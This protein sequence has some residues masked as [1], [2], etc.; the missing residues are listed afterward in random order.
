M[1]KILLLL[2][3]LFVTV[4]SF[5]QSNA[6]RIVAHQSMPLMAECK[7]LLTG[8]HTT[9]RWPVRLQNMEN[10]DNI[11]PAVKNMKE[12]MLAEK[13]KSSAIIANKI[14]A[15]GQVTPVLSTNFS[16]N[17]FDGSYPSDNTIAISNSGKIVS[18]INSNICYFTTTGTNT[19]SQDVTQFTN[20]NSVSSF[21]F[22]P[23]VL[24][25]AGSDRFFMVMLA[26][27]TAGNSD[28]LLY[29][30]KTN[31][32]TDGWWYYTIS[33]GVNG[34]NAWADYPNIGVSN[35][36][37]YVTVNQF[38]SND[39]F[40]DVVALQ[41]PKTTCY[42]GGT[43]NFQYYDQIQ[44]DAGH[45]TFSLYPI[46]SGN[47]TNYGPGIYMVSN[48]DPSGSNL[49][50]LFQISDDMSSSSEQLF[51]TSISTTP[52][53][54]IGANANQPAPGN[55][56]DIGDCRIKG[57]FFLNGIAHLVFTANYVS[58]WN[59]IFYSRINTSNFTA[60][61]FKYGK[62]GEDWGY[63][64]IGWMGKNSNDKSTI[65]AFTKSNAS[66]KPQFDVLAVDD[67]GNSSTEIIVK[68]G[69]SYISMGQ[70]SPERWGDYTG[71]AKY[72]TPTSPTA[73]VFGIYGTSAND[74]GNWIAK[75]T[76]NSSVNAETIAPESEAVSVYPNPS[77]SWFVVIFENHELNPIDISIFD[78][79][80]KLI[81]ILVNEKLKP[82]DFK[83]SFNTSE[84]AK[85]TYILN[86]QSG[87]KNL[88][89]EKIIIQ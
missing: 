85:G 57:G 4:V 69:A 10:E 20:D 13:K 40:A 41:I 2:I 89:N 32:P 68:Q 55:D 16:G 28:I 82:G 71:M 44:D 50:Q 6:V 34:A 1:K 27:Y 76:V 81:K 35:N 87:N 36:E 33:A 5:A 12:K 74:Y 54:Q 86:I 9:N 21:L 29:F 11:F 3:I 63:P 77:T 58:G 70:G 31:N 39:N 79:Q 65:I 42:A 46:S 51:G 72:H 60:T 80:G 38:D 15:N 22:D 48:T 47:D 52:S 43:M 64:A 62:N 18:V 37:V 8:I 78:L 59:G 25:D 30:S 61:S 53:F 23:K 7:G 84:L 49:L 14:E 19:F 45:F 88:K 17:Q 67:A 24:Y 26:G 56:L 75:I 83:F 73:F 66:I